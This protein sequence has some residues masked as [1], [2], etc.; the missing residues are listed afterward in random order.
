M[1]GNR[2]LA[3]AA[4]IVDL[5]DEPAKD[6]DLVSRW[7][8]LPARLQKG[9]RLR[10]GRIFLFGSVVRMGGSEA[11]CLVQPGWVLA[12]TPDL[13]D[14]SALDPGSRERLRRARVAAPLLGLGTDVVAIAW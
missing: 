1:E 9:Q 10:R 12:Q 7:Q 2:D 11:E 14:Q 3:V 5:G 13:R 8:R 6:P 4:V